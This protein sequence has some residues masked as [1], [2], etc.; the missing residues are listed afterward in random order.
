MAQTTITFEYNPE[1]KQYIAGTYLDSEGNVKGSLIL[2]D[3]PCALFVE[4]P[5]HGLF[6]LEQTHNADAAANGKYSPTGQ[7]TYFDDIVDISLLDIAGVY[8][9]Y[10]K[11]VSEKEI[12]TAIIYEADPQ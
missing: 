8:P 10:M 4:R 11:F 2:I 1:T 6:S 5:E 12:T 7:R 9:V 3:K